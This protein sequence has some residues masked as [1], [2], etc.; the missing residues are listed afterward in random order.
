MEQFQ[1]IHLRDGKDNRV[2]S[3][4]RRQNFA[5]KEF[6]RYY[7][8]VVES[9]SPKHTE[10]ITEMQEMIIR[11]S[12]NKSFSQNVCMRMR[13]IKNT[14]NKKSKHSDFST[15]VQTFVV[16]KTTI[17]ILQLTHIIIKLKL[18]FHVMHNMNEKRIF[19]LKKREKKLTKRSES[20]ITGKSQRNE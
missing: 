15:L 10:F 8:R 9:N 13:V 4:F 6:L 5:I 14:P 11:L 20:Q 18:A 17:H 19:R 2:D 16:N 1:L 7:W 3:Q 12:C